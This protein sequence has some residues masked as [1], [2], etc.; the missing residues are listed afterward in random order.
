MG[1][2]KKARILWNYKWQWQ[3]VV[4]WSRYFIHDVIR[5]INI[6]KAAVAVSQVWKNVLVLPPSAH[7]CIPPPNSV[8]EHHFPKR[9]VKSTNSKEAEKHSPDALFRFVVFYQCNTESV[10]YRIFAPKVFLSTYWL[11]RKV[12]HNSVWCEPLEAREQNVN[13]Y[14]EVR[15]QRSEVTWTSRAHTFHQLAKLAPVWVLGISYALLFSF[16]WT[17]INCFDT[18]KHACFVCELYNEG[19]SVGNFHTV[20]S[21]LPHVTWLVFMHPCNGVLMINLTE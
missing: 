18:W 1:A 4:N 17:V 11:G 16:E 10:Y 13:V 12:W 21:D 8:P 7:R 5:W 20:W 6:W 15:K 14:A 19:I 9:S 3:T 2:M